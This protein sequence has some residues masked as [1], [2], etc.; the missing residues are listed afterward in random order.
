MSPIRGRSA[1]Q[2]ERTSLAWQRTAITALVILF[3]MVLLSLRIG[4]PVLAAVGALAALA[5]TAV[6]GSVL[7]RVAQLDDDER[8]YSPYPP[9][10]RVA[11][12]TVLAGLG[13]AGVG[14]VVFLR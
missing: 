2:P 11:A 6:V 5:S 3:P 9:M 7:R 1:L 14:L 13:G 4:Q 12:V 10:A 8:R